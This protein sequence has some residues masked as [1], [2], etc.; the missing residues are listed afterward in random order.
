MSKFISGLRRDRSNGQSVL[1]LA[2][3]M[4]VLLLL[5]LGT[6]DM[7]RVFFDYIEMRN[8]VVEGATYGSRHPS[9]T[10]GITNA[11]VRHG[12]PGGTAIIAGTTGECFQPLGGGSVTVTATRTFTPI[13]LGG[14]NAVA[15][16]VNWN[17]TVRASS[18]IRCMT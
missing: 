12:I 14:L 10:A 3:A 17:F 2:L 6:V 13:F 11:V 1:E 16:D 4:P 7:G 15:P 5:L 18:T 9:D 8:A